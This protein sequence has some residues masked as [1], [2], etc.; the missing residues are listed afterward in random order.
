MIQEAILQYF[1]AIMRSVVPPYLP[2][3]MQLDKFPN[4]PVSSDFAEGR[5]YGFISRL[6][7]R[8]VWPTV[9][10]SNFSY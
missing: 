4:L 5:Q 10:G 3:L 2:A 6:E 7:L 8:S 9:P 1:S